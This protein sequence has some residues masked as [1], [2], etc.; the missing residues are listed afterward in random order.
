[1]KRVIPKGADIQTLRLRLEKLSTQKEM[2]NEIGVSI[3]K[4]WKIE[5]ENAPISTATANLPSVLEC[6][7]QFRRWVW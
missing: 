6:N 1:M 7:T 3:R 5:N 4:L 2:A